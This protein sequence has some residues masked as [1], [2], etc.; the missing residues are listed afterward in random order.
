MKPVK[1]NLYLA[2]EAGA[3]NTRFLLFSC[4]EGGPGVDGRKKSAPTFKGEL[5]VIRQSS[6][7][8]FNY[9]V[10]GLEGLRDVLVRLNRVVS[11][12]LESDLALKGDLKEYN[13][14]VGFAAAGIGRRGVRERFVE[15]FKQIRN[16]W[17]GE[18][19]VFAGFSGSRFF[20]I[21]D[22]ESALW[23]VFPN[24]VG[25]VVNAGT[26]SIAFARNE[27]GSTARSGG[28]GHIVGDE[29]SAYWIAVRALSLLLKVYDG[30]VVFEEEGRITPE[31][32]K[33]VSSAILK[34]LILER[35]GIGSVE[36]IVDWVH[37]GSVRGGRRDEK[38]RIS[39]RL[40]GRKAEIASLA[41]FV[42]QAAKEG[43]SMAAG[44][45]R[46]AGRE[47]YLLAK[48]VIQRV[49]FDGEPRVRMVGSVFSNDRIVR[50]SFSALL[51]GDYPRAD[52]ALSDTRPEMGVVNYLVNRVK[53][54]EQADFEWN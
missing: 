13:L 25:V 6:F 19:C 43:D 31:G 2:V 12:A 36:E 51:A 35:L 30:R 4:A 22:G 21:H 7:E 49:S 44:I 50:E 42:T 53:S 52:I 40:G 37:G 29:G 20:F 26:G 28:W 27:L 33:P 1:K 54:G 3:S 15:D 46:E 9:S 39:E 45:L 23:S 18:G 10:S 48:S 8:G 32:V 34:R 11:E 47:L 16:E 14:T 38:V 41:R 24:G 17:R 5:R